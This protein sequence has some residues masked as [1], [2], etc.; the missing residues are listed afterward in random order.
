MS[1][2]SQKVVEDAIGC[3]DRGHQQCNSTGLKK[4]TSIS[5]QGELKQWGKRESLRMFSLIIS[6]GANV[7]Q[8]MPYMPLSHIVVYPIKSDRGS[9]LLGQG[10]VLLDINRQLVLW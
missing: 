5:Q 6:L 7:C 4:W 3:L 9:V 10:E 8:P 2:P 1:Q